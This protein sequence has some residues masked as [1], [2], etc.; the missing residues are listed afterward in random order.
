MN[1]HK[2][3]IKNGFIIL[4][5]CLGMLACKKNKCWKC[6]MITSTRITSPGY[7]RPET[8]DTSVF[9]LCDRTAAQIRDLEKE[10]TTLRQS[11]NAYILTNQRTACTAN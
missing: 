1:P 9:V 5:F 8:T 10:K 7:V 2:A 6:T 3:T 4:A 11:G